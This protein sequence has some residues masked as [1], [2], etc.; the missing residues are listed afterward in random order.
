MAQDRWTLQALQAQCFSQTGQRPS[1]ESLRRALKR[2][3]YSWKR[4]KCTITSPDPD[5]QAK[6][7]QSPRW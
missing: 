2:F 6:K 1:L 4:A 3:G 7:G 5:Y